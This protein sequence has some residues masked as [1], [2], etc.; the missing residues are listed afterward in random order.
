MSTAPVSVPDWLIAQ[1][2]ERHH[3]T[4]TEQRA[5]AWPGFT[6]A[7]TVLADGD[8]GYVVRVALPGFSH[9]TPLESQT[10]SQEQ[11]AAAGVPVPA[12]VATGVAQ[13]PDGEIPYQIQAR[14]HGVSGA[15]VAT[16]STEH[17]LWH[18]LGRYAGR[19][20]TSRF[21]DAPDDL[22]TRF[23]RDPEAAWTAHLAHHGRVHH[24]GG[25]LLDLEVY[26]TGDLPGLRAM[27][28]RL[29]SNSVRQDLR[30]GLVHGDPGPHNLL[31]PPGREPVLLDW[32]NARISL[33]GY[34]ELIDPGDLA[35]TRLLDRNEPAQVEAIEAA[36][37]AGLAE[38]SG[39]VL[40]KE[41]LADLRLLSALDLVGWALDRAPER[42]N[43]QVAHARAQVALARSAGTI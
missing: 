18:T 19:A 26:D 36:Y 24:A 37:I 33:I 27:L 31:I 35:G 22:F 34:D 12:V 16:A 40:K 5:P 43:E 13:G 3:L 11:A 23:G 30:F 1:V 9:G 14:V 42:V 6:H 15:E 39:I 38:E 25:R 41:V 8:A 21:E 32:G 10:W 2:T 20:A 4:W 28:D 29:E 7:V 17:A